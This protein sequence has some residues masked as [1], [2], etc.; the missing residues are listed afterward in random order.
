MPR[1]FSARGATG[2]Y[3]IKF[4]LRPIGHTYKRREAYA[5]TWVVTEIRNPAVLREFR[6]ASNGR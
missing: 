5:G 3:P 2:G 1:V 4:R 6:E